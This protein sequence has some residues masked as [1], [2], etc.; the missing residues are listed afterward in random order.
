MFYKA[1]L[2][3]AGEAAGLGLHGQRGGPG[4]TGELSRTRPDQVRPGREIEREREKEREGERES[5]VKL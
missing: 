3:G 2:G 1:L 5:V 4:P